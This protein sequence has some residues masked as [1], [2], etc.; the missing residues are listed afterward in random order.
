MTGLEVEIPVTMSLYHPR[1]LLFDSI[2][3][4]RDDFSLSFERLDLDNAIF[5]FGIHFRCLENLH[6]QPV[7]PH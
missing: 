4:H 5:S 2:F 7:F 6:L 3:V 1:K